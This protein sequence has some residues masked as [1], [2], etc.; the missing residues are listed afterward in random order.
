MLLRQSHIGEAKHIPNAV[1]QA[2]QVQNYPFFTI[3]LLCI[4]HFFAL[5]YRSDM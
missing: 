4:T 1:K 2:S 5:L 3:L